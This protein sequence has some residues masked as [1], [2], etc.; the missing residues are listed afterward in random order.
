MLTKVRRDSRSFEKVAAYPV[1]FKV[2]GRVL[3]VFLRPLIT[4]V[5]NDQGI[6]KLPKTRVITAGT[7]FEVLSRGFGRYSVLSEKYF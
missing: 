5:R 6:A 2:I 7:G 3:M 1:L 4:Y